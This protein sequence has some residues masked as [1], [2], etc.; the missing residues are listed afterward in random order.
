MK[1]RELGTWKLTAT[2]G[3]VRT[4]GGWTSFTPV[5][6][7]PTYEWAVWPAEPSVTN[8]ADGPSGNL[9]YNMGTRFHLVAAANCVGVRWRVPDSVPLPD[10]VPHAVSLFNVTT[11][12]RI[13]HKEFTP[14]PGGYQDILFDAPVALVAAPQEYV[15]SVFTCHYVYRAAEPANGWLV[16]SPSLNIRCDQSRLT[17]PPSGSY[18]SGIFQTWYF[19]SPLVTV[20]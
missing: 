20:P 19:V 5:P 18:P 6:P 15:A 13:A 7:A 9:T 3:S 2:A 4:G 8:A 16:R 1:A 11:Q 17:G 10:G 12:V 14:T